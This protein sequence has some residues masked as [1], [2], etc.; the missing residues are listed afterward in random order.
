MEGG[1]IEGGRGRGGGDSGAGAI[2]CRQSR[3][4]PRRESGGAAGRPG[5]S[6]KRSSFQ[7]A[8][9]G[10][11][12]VA[13]IGSTLALTRRGDYAFFDPLVEVKSAIGQRFY[14]APDEKA[15]QQGALRGMVDA[16]DDPYTVY[17]PASETR[18]FE[19]ELTGDFVG[20]GVQIVIKDGWLTV[21][22]PLEDSP[23]FKAG[24]MAED[25]I[26]EVEGKSTFG[27]SSERCI[28]MLT[29]S[30]GTKV[31]FVVERDGQKL[32][33]TL[34]RQRIVAR[35]VKGFHWEPGGA[36]GAGSWQYYIDPGRGVAYVRLTQFTPTSADE[37]RDALVAIGAGT[38]KL[39][40]LI[41][42]LRWNP[43][44][45]MQDAT[46][47]AD[48]FL[49][50][51][52]IVS[53]K[54]R[55]RA[56]EVTRAR[57][58]G[59]LP[60]FPL[61]VLINGGSASA[62]EILAGSLTENGRAVAVGTRTFGKGLVQSVL[63]LPS[64]QGQLKITEQRYYLPSG[65]CIQRSDDSAE[66][67]V[68]PTQGFYVP[69]SDEE[70]AAMVKA[71]AQQEVIK[72]SGSSNPEERWADPEWI[73]GRLK[74]PQLA[75]A[76]KAVQGRID[77]GPGAEWRP[78]GKELPKG[79]SIASADLTK[80]QKLR[81]RMEGELIK[82]DRRIEQLQTAAADAKVEAVDL[83]PDSVDV[84]DGRLEVYDKGGRLVA[85]LRITGP[86]LERWLVDAEVKKEEGAEGQ[87]HGGV[88]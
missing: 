82:L 17:V 50:Q 57:E 63:T 11:L 12:G 3:L 51:G 54:G 60:E 40:G 16:L 58:E 31:S 56:E 23:A 79:A 1:G 8:L 74:D 85:R 75:A 25:R 6:K 35:T 80:A 62:S 10:I 37:F 67:G 7:G 2:I 20:I 52:V 13:V 22:T 44:G 76:L 29:G 5:V 68:D 81:D 33:M 69:M 15:M 27:L 66:W 49:K 30:P 48:L 78:T 87:R 4:G 42:D 34:E 65:R 71:R 72:A 39:K 53:T 45:V 77:A 38:E 24:M 88:K 83:W 41:L 36:E 9:V 47:I 84:T 32:P 73:I 14:K 64:G 61:A 43:G 19:K 70:M 28:E 26:V 59:T 86:D 55:A 46:A 18:E 21:V